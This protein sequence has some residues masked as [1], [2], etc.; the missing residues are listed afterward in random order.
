MRLRLLKE[1]YL[2]SSSSSTRVASDCLR[3]EMF[4]GMSELG[5]RIEVSFENAP[6]LVESDLWSPPSRS[7]SARR[8]R[9]GS[10]V[11]V[12]GLFRLEFAV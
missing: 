6:S 9:G 12:K 4:S 3:G 2:S 8:N 5:D 10:F 1:V 11:S 7:L